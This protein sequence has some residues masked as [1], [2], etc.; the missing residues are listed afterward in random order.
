MLK[1]DINVNLKIV[2]SNDNIIIVNN[3]YKVKK[4]LIRVTKRVEN[5]VILMRNNR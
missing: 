1:Y 2:K 5:G 3:I 4:E